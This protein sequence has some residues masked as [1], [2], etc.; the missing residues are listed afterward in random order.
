[1]MNNLGRTKV[2]ITTRGWLYLAEVSEWKALCATTLSKKALFEQETKYFM[3][4]ALE[5]LKT[6]PTIGS[7]SIPQDNPIKKCCPRR[8]RTAAAFTPSITRGISPELET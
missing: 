3:Q 8:R 7:K 5:S 2:E 4:M 1:M 6:R